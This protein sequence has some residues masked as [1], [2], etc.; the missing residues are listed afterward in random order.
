MRIITINT[1]LPTRNKFIYSGNVEF[2]RP[3]IDKLSE[4]I[5]DNTMVV[6]DFLLQEVVE[7]LKKVVVDWREV[8]R[9][10]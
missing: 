6:E 3:G 2:Q 10:W 7:M 9:V 4:G 8:W 5:F 1:F